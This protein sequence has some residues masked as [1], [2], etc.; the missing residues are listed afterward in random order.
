MKSVN[1]NG[2]ENGGRFIM[3]PT[4]SRRSPKGEGGSLTVLVA[5][6]VNRNRGKNGGDS[7]EQAQ[8]IDK[9][10]FIEKNVLSAL[11]ERR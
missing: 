11:T 10:I 6:L 9:K 1:E 8:L 3:L 2:D 5:V 4:L 7:L